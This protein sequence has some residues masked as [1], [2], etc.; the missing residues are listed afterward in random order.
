MIHY[1]GKQIFGKKIP[2]KQA[3][4]ANTY[5]AKDIV[6]YLRAFKKENTH[7][8]PMEFVNSENAMEEWH[9]LID[10]M[11]WSFD[12]ISND[13]SGEYYLDK[14]SD[15]ETYE[16]LQKEYN[17]KLKEGLNLFAK[18]FCDLWD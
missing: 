9:A 1:R 12:Q 8:T 6:K 4:N 15:N 13:Y 3:W 2:K 5:M 10:K 11:I 18:Y 16:K 14:I 7:T 17:E